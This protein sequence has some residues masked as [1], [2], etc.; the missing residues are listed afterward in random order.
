MRGFKRNAGIFL[1]AFSFIFLIWGI[2]SNL[3]GNA[4]SEYFKNSFMIIHFLGLILLVF[5]IALF[6]LF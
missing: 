4:V 3:T 6:I 2:D 5:G 1:L